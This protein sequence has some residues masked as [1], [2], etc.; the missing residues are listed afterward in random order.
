MRTPIDPQNERELKQSGNRSL[1]LGFDSTATEEIGSH[2]FKFGRQR[3]V[4]R[5]FIENT[6]CDQHRHFFFPAKPTTN[7][8]PGHLSSE[9]SQVLGIVFLGCLLSTPQFV[10]TEGMMS[11]AGFK[12][13]PGRERENCGVKA[14]IM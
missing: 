1:L 13:N 5:S 11:L 3:S 4:T 9:M 6:Y 10:W 8:I 2:F 14:L 12:L 7:L